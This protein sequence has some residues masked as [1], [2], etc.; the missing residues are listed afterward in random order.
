MAR[1]L[2]DIDGVLADLLPAWLDVWTARSGQRIHPLEVTRYNFAAMANDPVAFQQALARVA[3]G[4]VRPF[5]W[6]IEGVERLRAM[7]HQLRFISY[8]PGE[9]HKHFAQKARWLE[10]HVP[11]FAPSELIFC[12]SSEKQYVAGDIL[13]ED[14]P[15]SLDEWLAAHPISR[16]FL[17]DQLYNQGWS[18]ARCQRVRDV[19][20]AAEILAEETQDAA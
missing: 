4:Q 20:Q 16:G 15:K 2:C 7:G 1:I 5:T 14:Y 6:G 11:G 10:R 12:G 19:A 8:V 13:I 3:Y 17:I 18:H 9:A